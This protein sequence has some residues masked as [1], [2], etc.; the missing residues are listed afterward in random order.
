MDK[1]FD[2]KDPGIESERLIDKISIRMK[3][4]SNQ[5][6][7]VRIKDSKLLQFLG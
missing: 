4:A 1:K 5:Q 6:R 2:R 3:L 7:T